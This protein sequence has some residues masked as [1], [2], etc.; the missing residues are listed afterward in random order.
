MT[1]QDDL[2]EKAKSL[3]ALREP[4]LMRLPVPVATPRRK[5]RR[6]LRRASLA[7]APRALVASYWGWDHSRPAL[8][9]GFAMGN[10]RLEADAVDIDTK[11][12]GRVLQLD[13]DEGDLVKRGQVVAVMDTRDLQASLK[14]YQELANGLALLRVRKVTSQTT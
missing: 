1:L 9:P 12:S 7:L 14:Q 3:P 10:G 11:F 6:W 4:P 13:A 2:D 5:P 8:P